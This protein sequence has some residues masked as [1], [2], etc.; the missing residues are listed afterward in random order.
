MSRFALCG[1]MAAHAG[2]RDA[3][4]AVMKEALSGVSKV[5]GCL[6]YLVFEDLEDENC[7][8]ITEIWTS[9]E[10]HD[11]SLKDPSVLRTISMAREYLDFSRMTQAK[12]NPLF[13][14]GMP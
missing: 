5:P 2:K 7:L 14:V 13:G 12:L 4:T 8:W 11:S 1:K 6:L 3:L 10:A 9:K